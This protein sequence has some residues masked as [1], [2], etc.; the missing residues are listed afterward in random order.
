[1]EVRVR[2][3]DVR[4]THDL[5]AADGRYHEKCRKSFTGK[6]NVSSASLGDNEVIDE[7]FDSL[8]RAFI[9]YKCRM[10]KTIELEKEY[11]KLGGSL[12]TR[13]KMVEKL[14][15]YFLSPKV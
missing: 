4:A 11:I 14:G 13:R 9:S 6:R 1:M 3:N 7:S 2:L 12:L 8:T 5:H 10:W 15:K